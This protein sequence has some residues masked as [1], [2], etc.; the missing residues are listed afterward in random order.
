MRVEDA[1]SVKRLTLCEVEGRGVSGAKVIA[2]EDLMVRLA[3]HE[4][5]GAVKVETN[6]VMMQR[7]RE[8]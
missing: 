8:R 3:R 7:G 1:V 2:A 4:D 6:D 5:C